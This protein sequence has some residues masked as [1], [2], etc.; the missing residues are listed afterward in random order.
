[1]NDEA[2]VRQLN[3]FIDLAKDRGIEIRHEL[4]EGGGGGICQIRG[5]PCLFLDLASGPAEQL[6]TIRRTLSASIASTRVN[7]GTST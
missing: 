1:M 3:A 6:E 2:I 5:K 7:P 4:L